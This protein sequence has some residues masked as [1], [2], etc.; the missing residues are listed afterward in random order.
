MPGVGAAR[1]SL[2]QPL[3]GWLHF[4]IGIGFGFVAMLLCRFVACGIAFR[5][6][7]DWREILGK[8]PGAL[9]VRQKIYVASEIKLIY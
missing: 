7:G 9:T 5:N 4:G 1:V 8:R 2:Q 3:G 6:C